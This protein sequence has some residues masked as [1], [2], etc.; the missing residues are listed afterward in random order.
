M[1]LGLVSRWPITAVT[2]A[3]M[4]SKGRDLAALVA[5]VAHPLGELRVVVGV[6]SWEP[7]RWQES[8]QQVG[9]LQR[10]TSGGAADRLPPSTL[11]ADLNCDRSQ[12]PLAD[13]RLHDAWDASIPAAD[14]R[15]L[16]STHEV[17]EMH[18]RA[19]LHH[20][21][22]RRGSAHARRGQAR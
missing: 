19:H 1:G 21:E 17:S 4:P 10:L 7:E 8:T 13:L 5:A 3:P 14:P 12:E 15:T 22:R 20:C 11:L 18:R 6:T 16:S 9:E 2:G